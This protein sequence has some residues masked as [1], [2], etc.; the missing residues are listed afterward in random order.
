MPMH[1]RIDMA[2]QVIGRLT[3]L[4]LFPCG[5]GGQRMVELCLPVFDTMHRQRRESS[6]RTAR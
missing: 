5:Q 1:E 4:R 6:T 2:G 3:V